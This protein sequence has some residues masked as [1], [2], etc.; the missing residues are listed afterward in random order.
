MFNV[1]DIHSCY[2]YNSCYHFF[3]TLKYIDVFQINVLMNCKDAF[4]VVGWEKVLHCCLFGI[5]ARGI[6]F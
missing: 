4:V 2:K 3:L 5:V 6:G 1:A